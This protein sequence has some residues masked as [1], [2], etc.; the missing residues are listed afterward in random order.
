VVSRIWLILDKKLNPLAR[1]GIS[2]EANAIAHRDHPL[3]MTVRLT[4]LWRFMRP[5]GPHF[6]ELAQDLLG[7]TRAVLCFVKR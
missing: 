6:E 7:L 3:F 5:N 2:G 1:S 4:A